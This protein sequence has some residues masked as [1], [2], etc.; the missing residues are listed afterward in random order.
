MPQATFT[1][2]G[3]IEDFTRLDNLYKSLVR[4]SDKLLSE[5]ELAIAVSYSEKQ[6]EK[7]TT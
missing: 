3:K 7:E 2:V 6:G 5:W 4:E 1:L